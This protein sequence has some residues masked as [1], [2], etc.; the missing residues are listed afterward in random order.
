M[1]EKRERR[2]NSEFQKNIY[3]ILKNRVKDVELT[4]MFTISEV[5]V[6]NDLKHAKVFVS[7]YSTNEIKRQKT[8]EAICRAG[9]FVRKELGNRM[10]IHSIP[11]LHFIVDT[12]NEYGNKIDAIL[13]TL[14]YG[15]DDD[16]S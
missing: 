4:E 10:K 12:A 1:K 9:G 3:D 5:D 16:K 6:T 11:E 13:S 15:E 14:T 2:L 7:V 8:F